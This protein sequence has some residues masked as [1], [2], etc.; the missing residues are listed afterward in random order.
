MGSLAAAAGLG[1]TL[2][3]SAAGWL[4]GALAAFGFIW[5]A[6]PLVATLLL[7]VLWPSLSGTLM[8][9]PRGRLA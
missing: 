2:G 8:K 5:L 6:L 7:L 3:A 9:H 4:F 1:Q